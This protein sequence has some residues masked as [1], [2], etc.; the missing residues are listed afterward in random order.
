MIAYAI[1]RRPRPCEHTHTYTW[2]ETGTLRTGSG[3]L[4][5]VRMAGQT[6]WNCH[7]YYEDDDDD[8]DDH[9]DGFYYY[10]FD[11]NCCKQ[12]CSGQGALQGKSETTSN[13]SGQAVMR[14]TIAAAHASKLYVTLYSSCAGA[15][16]VYML[17]LSSS[18]LLGLCCVA[19]VDVCSAVG[20]ALLQQ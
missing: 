4:R 17:L 11:C 7:C 9:D 19:D 16:A 12:G 6:C 1:L 15:C 18:T 14:D 2:T 20:I 13:S 3:K 10:C 8:D 5:M